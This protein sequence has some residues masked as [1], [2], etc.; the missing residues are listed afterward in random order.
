MVKDGSFLKH[1]RFYGTWTEV[2]KTPQCP[3]DCKATAKHVV[4]LKRSSH[5]LNHLEAGFQPSEATFE[6]LFVHSF[7]FGIYNKLVVCINDVFN[8]SA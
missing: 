1:R 2:S 4:P 3:G 5:L 8:P 7:L 6:S